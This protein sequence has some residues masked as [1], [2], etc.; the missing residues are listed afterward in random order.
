MKKKGFFYRYGL[1]VFLRTTILSEA[2][3]VIETMED[4]DMGE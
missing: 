4:I 2:L 3:E 1:M